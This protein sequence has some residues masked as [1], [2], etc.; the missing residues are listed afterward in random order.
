VQ[1]AIET[2]HLR[3]SRVLAV[4]QPHG[5]TPTRFLRPDFV[6]SFSAAL[7]P[8][9]RLWL[10]EIFYAGGTAQ[11]DFSAAEIA[12]DIVS[13]GKNAE[14]AAT[15]DV[16]QKRL[17]EEARPGDLILIMGARDPSL[18]EF[19]RGLVRCLETR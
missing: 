16:L 11:R 7:R 10:L 18:T 1:A 6:E 9:D 12:D 14:F 13:N 2:A 5:F 17:L 15:R 19:G 3:G 8:N 4:Y